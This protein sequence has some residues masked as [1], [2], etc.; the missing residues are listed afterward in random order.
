MAIIKIRAIKA[1]R[2]V[3]YMTPHHSPLRGDEYGQDSRTDEV[4]M[5]EGRKGFA[6]RYKKEQ[7][8]LSNCVDY[9][10]TQKNDPAKNQR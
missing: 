5:R 4:R 9:Q 10:I 7:T 2:Q 1:R 8:A 3:I 6:C